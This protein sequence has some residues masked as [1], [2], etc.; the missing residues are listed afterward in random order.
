LDILNRYRKDLVE[1]MDSLVGEPALSRESTLSEAE[2]KGPPSPLLT[3]CRY[4]LGLA[5]ADGAP[6]GDAAGKMLR[7]VLCLAM[8]EALGGDIHRCLPAA[9]SLELVHRS[10]LIFDDIQD[11]SI[12]R[13]HRPTTWGVWGVDQAINAGLALSCYARL[14]LHGILERGVSPGTF[15]EV[16]RLLEHTVIDL[17]RGQYLDIHFQRETSPGSVPSIDDYMKMVRLKTGVLLGAACQVGALIAG[18]PEKRVAAQ[19]FGEAVGVAFQLR[20]DI[21]GVWGAAATLGKPPG[22]LGERKRSLPV[23]LAV[24]REPSLPT[25]LARPAGDGEV[26]TALLQALEGA[27]ARDLCEAQLRLVAEE[28]AK[29]L[30]NLDI[31]DPWQAR[32]RSLVRFVMERDT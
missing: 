22:D 24:A 28:A 4:H 32:F 12:Q 7:P 15:L 13:N 30:F 20:D 25:L 21:L 10:S 8:C 14:A 23:V 29:A 9:L 19:G 3:M 2:G 31:A 16:Q 1:A 27:G 17:C 6:R 26:T 18:A 5:E 11:R